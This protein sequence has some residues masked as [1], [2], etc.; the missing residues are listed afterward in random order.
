MLSAT[1]LDSSKLL[2]YHDTRSAL[3]PFIVF[4]GL[5]QVS[6]S[7]IEKAMQGVEGTGNLPTVCPVVS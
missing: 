7:D 4:N 2:K 1:W 5:A 3:D 6:V